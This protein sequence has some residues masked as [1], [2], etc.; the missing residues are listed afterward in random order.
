MNPPKQ[1]I[2]ATLTIY[3]GLPF[4]QLFLYQ[5]EEGRP[6]DITGKKAR[7][8]LRL[9][10]ESADPPLYEFSTANG[11][12][13]TGKGTFRILGMTDVDTAAI[14]W[15]QAVGHFVI[16]EI[17]GEPRPL[18]YLLFNALPVTSGVPL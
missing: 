4:S 9:S 17:A 3:K 5:T 15:K 18:I 10:A 12:I 2:H 6:V 11:K 7:L 16:E 14:N 8:Q 13:I 1:T